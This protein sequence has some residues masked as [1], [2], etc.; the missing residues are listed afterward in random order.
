MDYSL[1]KLYVDRVI[2]PKFRGYTSNMNDSKII[3][4]SVDH[5]ETL[6]RDNWS[7]APPPTVNGL[8]RRVTSSAPSLAIHNIARPSKNCG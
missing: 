1:A 6:A 4:E 7:L 8:W 5:A 3:G 2:L